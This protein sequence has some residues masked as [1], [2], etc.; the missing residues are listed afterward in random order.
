MTFFDTTEFKKRDDA[1]RTK[2]DRAWAEHIKEWPNERLGNLLTPLLAEMRLEFRLAAGMFRQLPIGH[3]CLVAQVVKNEAG[4][5]ATQSEMDAGQEREEKLIVDPYPEMQRARRRGSY[6]GI[7]VG[8]G[9]LARDY[10]W[11]NGVEL[12]H[13]VRFLRTTVFNATVDRLRTPDGEE[14]VVEVQDIVSTDIR[15]S[16]N[17]SDAVLNTG[18]HFELYDGRHIY[19]GENGLRRTPTAPDA[20]GAW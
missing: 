11:S 5:L 7:L 6:E 16:Y 8:A 18:A 20:E 1:K 15:T 12:G 3:N 13:M 17:L 9:Q 19:V 2:F 14:V 4:D 10:L